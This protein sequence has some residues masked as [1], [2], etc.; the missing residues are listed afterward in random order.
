MSQQ[1]QTFMFGTAHLR[2][3][4]HLPPGY[5]REK[6][7]RWP[8]LFFF[9]DAP[10]RGSDIDL[11][12][13]HG[14]PQIV[15]EQP[16]FPFITIAPQ[17]PA[18]TWWSFELD[19]L[20]GLI[21]EVVRAL[22]VDPHHLY[23]TGIGMGGYAT[24]G[25]GILHPERFAALVPICGG[26]D[27]DEACTLKETPVWAF[28]GA[29]DNVVLLRESRKMVDALKE[30]GGKIRFTIYPNGGHDVWTRAYADPRLID[31]LLAHER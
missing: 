3:L 9:H 17:C 4:V 11:M 29:L 24:W 16:D 10:E 8:T 23:L 12:K 26:S 28:H 2:Y 18:G 5:E 19:K 31:W 14:I 6:S 20:S 30:C 22:R 1:V 27:P 21:D 13:Q 25:L 15:E 7:R